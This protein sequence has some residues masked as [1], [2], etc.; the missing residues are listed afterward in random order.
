M[1]LAGLRE[2]AVEL[3][4]LLRL[5][6]YTIALKMLSFVLGGLA[7]ERTAPGL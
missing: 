5:Q 7:A 4:S 2:A 1:D 6:T 3:E